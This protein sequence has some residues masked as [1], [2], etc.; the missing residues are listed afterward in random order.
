[1]TVSLRQITADTVRQITD[2]K[3]SLEQQG[4]VAPNAVSLAQ[5]LFSEEAWYRAISLLTWA[6]KCAV[7]SDSS[8]RLRR[9]LNAN[10]RLVGHGRLR[11]T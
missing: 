5:A 3:V 10:V 11:K 6:N 1:M 2:L 9:R 8:G 7:S 4:F